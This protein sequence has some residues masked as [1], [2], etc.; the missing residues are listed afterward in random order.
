[1]KPIN[2]GHSLAQ[3]W[4]NVLIP[5]P[6]KKKGTVLSRSNLQPETT[7]EEENKNI[8]SRLIHK[9]KSHITEKPIRFR[10]EFK[11]ILELQ[12]KYEC[13]LY[14]CIRIFVFIIYNI[15]MSWF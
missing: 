10:L 9:K 4:Q 1:M 2:T 5:P 3:K 14:V 7:L 6:P 13:I 12:I 11:E 8:K 15:S